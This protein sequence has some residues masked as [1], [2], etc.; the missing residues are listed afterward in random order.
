[1]FIEKIESDKKVNR[2]DRSLVE[3]E[4]GIQQAHK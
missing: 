2:I 1:M 4:T 3:M